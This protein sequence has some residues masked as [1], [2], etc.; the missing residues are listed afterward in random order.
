MMTF[1]DRLWWVS[2][3]VFAMTDDLWVALVAAIIATAISVH[4][5]MRCKNG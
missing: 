2:M 1:L 5:L 3:T 4:R